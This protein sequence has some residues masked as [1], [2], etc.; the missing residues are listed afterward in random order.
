MGRGDDVVR[1]ERGADAG[2][3]R[4]LPDVLVRHAGDLAR[5]ERPIAARAGDAETDDNRGVTLLAFQRF[6][7]A[8]AS[9]GRTLAVCPACGGALG[10]RRK[11]C[12]MRTGRCGAAARDLAARLPID[13]SEMRVR[14]RADARTHRVAGRWFARD[15]RWQAGTILP[16]HK[17]GI[18]IDLNE[19]FGNV[20]PAWWR[21]DS[22]P[23]AANLYRAA[24][25]VS[26]FDARRLCRNMEAAFVRR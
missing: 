17:I 13:R 19:C 5:F 26:L 3:D 25:C 18:R 20:R 16:R 10:R 7:D 12:L 4:L 24:T 22:A 21:A 9:F 6:D 14:L 8:L 15:D 23:G 11:C 2:R 1:A